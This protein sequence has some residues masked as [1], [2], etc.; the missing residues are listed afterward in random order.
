MF[1]TAEKTNHAATVVHQKSQQQTF[2]RRADEETFFGSSEKSS[3]FSTPVQTELSVSSPDDP[4]EKE[5]DAVAESVMRIPE[6]QAPSISGDNDEKIGKKEEEA[7]EIQAKIDVSSISRINRQASEEEEEVQA[8]LFSPVSRKS[9]ESFDQFGDSFANPG[10]TESISR[11]KSDKNITFIVHR[12]GRGPPTDSGSFGQTLQ[13]SKGSG[14]ALPGGTRDFMESR[15]NADFSGVR[16]HTGSAAQAMSSNIHAHAFAHGNDIYFNEGKYSPHTGGGGLLLAHE[17]THT[18]QQG[19]SP[20]KSTTQTAP[21]SISRKK[22]I[23]LSYSGVPDQLTNAVEDAKTVE[24]KTDANN[25]QPI[26]GNTAG[27]EIVRKEDNEKEINDYKTETDVQAKT[28]ELSNWFV[29]SGGVLNTGGANSVQPKNEPE[30]I[31]KKEED[32]REEEKAI[33]AKLIDHQNINS[34]GNE[35]EKDGPQHDFRSHSSAETVQNSKIQ[36]ISIVSSASTSNTLALSDE[37]NNRGPPVRLQNNGNIIQ[38][39]W[40]DDALSIVDSAADF[41]SEGL[42]AGKDMLLDEAR[43][44]AMAIPGYKALRVVLGEDPITG[45]EIVRNGHN[46]IEAAFDIMPGGNLLYDKLNELGA[47]TEAEQWI[48]N[49]IGAVESLVS[50]VVGRV[51]RFWDNLSIDDLAS[52]TQILE[53]AGNII[54][55]TIVEVTDFAVSA[56]TELLEIVKRWLLTQLVDFIKEHTTA[57]PLLT[58][59]IGEDPITNEPVTRNGTNILNAIL[60]LGGEEGVQQRT[61]MEETGTFQKAAGYIDRGIGVFGNLLETITG[62]FDLIWSVVSIEALMNP[63]DKFNE[64]YNVFAQPVTDVLQFM[65]DTVAVI[66]QF[67][68]E[69]LLQRLSSWAR[70]VRGYHLVTVIIGKDPFTNV[71]VERNVENIIRGFMS[72]MAGGEEQ[73]QQMKESGSIDR[74]SQQIEAAVNRLNMTPV[75]IIQLFIDLWNSFSFNDFVNPIETFE[76]IIATFGEPIGRLI[77]F[78][79]E[80]VKIVVVVLLEIMNFPF[81]IISNIINKT[82]SAFQSIKRD[83]IGFLKNILRAIKQGFIQFFGN[84]IS[85]LINGVVGWLMSELRDAGIPN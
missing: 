6:P 56:A 19:A 73:F 81:D 37:A 67:I 12:N 58:V 82:I 78:V 35:A 31:Q 74:A 46:F 34:T 11:K 18:I 42:E 16:V 2:F 47:L 10:I 28:P 59:I 29:D 54:I 49:G 14:S 65:A 52:P 4:Q 66:L 9:D 72:L 33:A 83:P 43:D 36:G 51:E 20:V 77:A 22:S 45:E 40:F 53:D 13:S 62:N 75:M 48:D 30:D 1:A 85:H 27:D 60:E 39:G 71:V 41:V 76:R 79:V 57:Y 24:G 7:E 15:F 23:Y 25:Q 32:P 84:I 69:V 68:K 44:F 70:G 64:I 26:N 3:F 5:A 63:V 80:I 61:Q 21:K 38:G 8:K 17:L 55:S 50:G